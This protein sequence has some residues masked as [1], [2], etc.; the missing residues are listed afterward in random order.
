MTQTSKTKT[1]KTKAVKS[2]TAS[3]AKTSAK[4]SKAKILIAY[5]GSANSDGA[6]SD[7]RHAG[8]EANGEAR[9]LTVSD[10]WIP[11]LE[12]V[13][14]AT[15]VV[16][17]GAFTMAQPLMRDALKDAKITVEKGAAQLR[18]NFPKWKVASATVLDAPAQ[19]ILHTAEKWHPTLIV[20]G[21]K[22]H[23]ALG[24]LLLGSVSH[25]VLTHATCSVRIAR[26]ASGSAASA[27][28]RVLLA[29]DGSKD[30]EAMLQS[31]LRRSWG[32]GAEFRV[33]VVLDY[34]LSLIQQYQ[35][36][37]KGPLVEAVPQGDLAK[38]LAEKAAQ[39]LTDK[40]LKTTFVI[41]EGDP[42]TE[43]EA[44]AKRFKAN[45]LFLGSHGLHAVRRFFLG[46]VS[47]ALAEHAPCSVE[48]VRR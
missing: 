13:S 11:S 14:V 24:R 15:D 2:K 28:P 35:P 23:T 26:P 36:G 33:I 32:K 34:K 4:T 45:N 16:F 7:L 10:P 37:Q 31:V 43:I 48:I 22:G 17:A 5:D 29:I 21:S 41:R 30:A 1:A 40:G 9:I 6:L 46:S 39:S 12:S 38:R 20:L 8:L 18:K 42:R 27:S 19:G 3:T 25:K 44:E 47:A